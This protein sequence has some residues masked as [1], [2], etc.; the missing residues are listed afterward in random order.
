MWAVEN[1]LVEGHLTTCCSRIAALACPGPVYSSLT[2]F[3]G[4]RPGAELEVVGRLR[5]GSRQSLAGFQQGI[6]V[7]WSE[8][9]GEAQSSLCVPCG[10]LGHRGCA[11]WPLDVL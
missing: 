6:A 8:P 4:L 11:D 5:R 10:A 9:S 1:A 3:L 7:A 2:V